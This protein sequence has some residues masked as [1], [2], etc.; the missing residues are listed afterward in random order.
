MRPSLQPSIIWICTTE[1]RMKQHRPGF[2][3]LFGLVVAGVSFALSIG[4]AERPNNSPAP[5]APPLPAIRALKLEP[6]SL[7]LK[8]GRDERRVLVLGVTEGEKFIDLTAEA[9][10][11]AGS[12][13]VEI[14]SQGYVRGKTKGAA[15]VVVSAAGKESKLPVTVEEAAVPAVRFVRD[16]M[17]I[18]RRGRT[19]SSFRCADTTRNTITR[20]SSTIF[21][22]AA[23][24][25]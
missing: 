12:T 24:T 18:V 11:T 17:P 22:A 19:G 15:E 2:L 8:D 6:A 25:A 20:R 3:F 16:V 21:P 14:D 7:T 13:N 5:A 23:S 10:F 4:A 9:T 1:K